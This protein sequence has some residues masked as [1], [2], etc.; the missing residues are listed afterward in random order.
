[1]VGSI[2]IRKDKLFVVA[3]WSLL[4]ILL[5]AGWSIATTTITDSEVTTTGNSTAAFYC[6][7]TECHLIADFLLD[8]DTTVGNDGITLNILNI[9]GVDDNACTGTDKVTNVTFNNGNLQLT[10]ASDTDTTVGNCSV[11]NSCGLITYDSELAYTGNDEITLNILNITGSDDNACSSTDKVSNVTFNNGNLQITCTADV[12]TT[13]SLTNIAFTN[14]S[15]IFTKNQNISS[16]N[17]TSVDCI[18]FASGGKICS[19]S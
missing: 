15:N 19:G 9:T 13:T 14:E 8:T 1:M 18:H 6:N 12:D 17:I 16:N 5:F 3:L 2:K 4:G 7:A 10:C 11:G